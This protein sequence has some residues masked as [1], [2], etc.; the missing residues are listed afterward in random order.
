MKTLAAVKIPADLTVPASV[1]DI[2]PSDSLQS[3]YDII[4]TDI[5]QPITIGVKNVVMWCDEEALCKVDPAFNVR[6]SIL[7]RRPI[8]GDTILAG[9]DEVTWQI[10]DLQIAVPKVFFNALQR[11]AERFVAENGNLTADQVLDS[12]G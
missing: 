4:G 8:F 6:A 11:E 9:E 5:V 7:A 2:N 1:V 12:M 10:I 3:M